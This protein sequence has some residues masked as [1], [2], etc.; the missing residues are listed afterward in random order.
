M[1]PCARIARLSAVAMLAAIVAGCAQD[2]PQDTWQPAGSNARQINDLDIWVF[3]IAGIVGVAVFS[4]LGFAVWKYRDRGQPIPEQTHG[5]PA[6]EIGL[7]ILPALILIGIAIPTVGTI[8]D[9]NKTDDTECVINVTGQQ[10]WW[11][12]DYPVQDGCGGIEEPIVTSGQMVIEAGSNVL[13]R[14]TSRDVIHSWWI[15]RLNGKRDMVP[16]RIH[17]VRLEA[18]EPGIYAGQCTEFCGLS[19]A[20]MRMEVIAME[21]DDFAAW[22]ANQLEAYASPAVGTLAAEGEATF[23]TQCSRCHQVDGLTDSGGEL[24]VARPDQNVWSGAAPNLTNFMTRNTFA[25]ATWNLLSNECWPDVWEADSSEVGAAY[26]EGV[27][28]SCL[29]EVELREWLRNAPAKKPMYTDPESLEETD[30]LPR[31]MPYL[32]LSE[33]QIDQLIAYLLE[34]K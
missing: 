6:L 20:N 15:P 13:V 25:G 8:M 19:H 33:D 5:K 24:V 32:A 21:P 31:G 22:K 4:V 7:T 11:E 9:L 14:G 17:T 23:I 29:N 16:G 3:S 27:S 34:R 10:W 18:D 2:A 1:T 26:L 12:V 30:G 28:D